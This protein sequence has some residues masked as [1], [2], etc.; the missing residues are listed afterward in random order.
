MDPEE[1]SIH[2]TFA[3]RERTQLWLAEKLL[4]G[5]IALEDCRRIVLPRQLGG[6]ELMRQLG[7]V[8]E[9]LVKYLQGL[10]LTGIAPIVIKDALTELEYKT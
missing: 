8:R 6:D 3:I 4:G 9:T 10:D 5:A 7:T 1:H 2:L